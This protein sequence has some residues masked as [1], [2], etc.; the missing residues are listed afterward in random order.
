MP[1]LSRK[2]ELFI[3]LF[4]R[5]LLEESSTVPSEPAGV[6]KVIVPITNADELVATY[7]VKEGISA[8]TAQGLYQPLTVPAK[9]RWKVGF[10]MA[11][12]ASGTFTVNRFYYSDVS[13]NKSLILYQTTG[14]VT[15]FTYLYNLV[16][17][18]GDRIGVLV[19]SYTGAGNLECRAVIAEEDAY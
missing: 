17:D 11:D 3:R 2:A 13:E 14:A 8:V 12:R 6:S 7:G 10:I 16:M 19:D 4:R 9:K 1:L 5:F 15:I 18:E